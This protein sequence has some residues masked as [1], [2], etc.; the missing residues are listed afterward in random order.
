[1]SEWVVARASDLQFG[2]LMLRS[3]Q[4]KYWDWT[5]DLDYAVVY[6]TR[7]AA[8]ADAD[9]LRMPGRPVPLA[10]VKHVRRLGRNA[11][12]KDLARVIEGL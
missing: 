12:D 8:Q 2:V 5:W 10:W 1:M 6:P 9:T 4:S 3:H 11:V 7:E